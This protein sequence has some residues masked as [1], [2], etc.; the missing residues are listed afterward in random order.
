VAAG[1]GF[2]RGELFVVIVVYLILWGALYQ[3][4]LQFSSFLAAVYGADKQY[5]KAIETAQKAIQ[6][7]REL[8]EGELAERI[9]GRLQ[10]YLRNESYIDQ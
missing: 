3:K 10:Y 4:K 9:E 2:W 1:G 6:L 7:S 5:S 8:R